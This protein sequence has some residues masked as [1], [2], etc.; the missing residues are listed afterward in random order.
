LC[1]RQFAR[2]PVS[3]QAAWIASISNRR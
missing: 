1:R 2:P 3:S